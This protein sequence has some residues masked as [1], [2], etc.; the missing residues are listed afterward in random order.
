MPKG[1]RPVSSLCASDS[2]DLSSE[3]GEEGGGESEGR[4][5]EPGTGHTAGH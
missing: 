1:G 3:E 4:D 2:E 5:S